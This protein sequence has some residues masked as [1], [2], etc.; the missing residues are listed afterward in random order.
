[1]KR[2]RVVV[3]EEEPT[4]VELHVGETI[5]FLQPH[6]AMS[7]GESL[8]NEGVTAKQILLGMKSPHS[9]K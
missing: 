2:V 6:E 5:V 3:D 9:P 8:L 7:L 1:M 4:L